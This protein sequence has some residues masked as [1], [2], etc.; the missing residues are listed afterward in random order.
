MGSGLLRLCSAMPDLQTH[1]NLLL[2]RRRCGWCAESVPLKALLRAD[3]CPH[4]GANLLPAETGAALHEALAG[5]WAV[6]S[7]RR[8]LLPGQA[9]HAAREPTT[10]RNTAG[11]TLPPLTTATVRRPP[12]TWGKPA[13]AT[14]PAPSAT[15]P[16][17]S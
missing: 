17:S 6:R 7:E 4:C 16:S 15:T 13:T 11:S 10:L 2:L 14:A 12:E 8:V 5:R 1:H 3:A 9:G